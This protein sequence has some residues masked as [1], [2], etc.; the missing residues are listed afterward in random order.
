MATTMAARNNNTASNGAS[1]ATRSWREGG[2][3]RHHRFHQALGT[4]EDAGASGSAGGNFM[5]FRVYVTV[6]PNLF[7]NITI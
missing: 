1:V 6:L 2:R 4:K 5:A 7:W 3:R